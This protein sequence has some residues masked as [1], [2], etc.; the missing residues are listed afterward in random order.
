MA[1]EMIYELNEHTVGNKGDFYFD[2]ES[3]DAETEIPKKLIKDSWKQARRK[4]PVTASNWSDWS[5]RDGGLNENRFKE[6]FIDGWNKAREKVNGKMRWELVKE[7]LDFKNMGYSVSYYGDG[8]N[9]ANGMRMGFDESWKALDDEPIPTPEFVDYYIKKEVKGMPITF[10]E[11][12]AD[13]P[14]KVVVQQT[15]GKNPST[16][17]IHDDFKKVFVIN[18]NY[19]NYYVGSIPN[20]Y[21]GLRRKL[22][23]RINDA[24]KMAKGDSQ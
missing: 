12:W 19:K 8:W 6:G 2:A 4:A 7:T 3:F 17:K 11:V 18:E 24:I 15:K 13:G 14:M 16:N 9:Y 10:E 23:D 1:G 5:G 22:E 20:A 21:G